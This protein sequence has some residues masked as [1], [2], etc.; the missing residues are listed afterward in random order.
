[1]ARPITAL[2]VRPELHVP[3]GSWTKDMVHTPEPL[4]PFGADVYL[5]ILNHA[6]GCVAEEF[7]VLIKGIEYLSLGG[8]VYSLTIPLVA[9]EGRTPAGWT[10]ATACRIV[11]VLRSRCHAAAQA[12]SSGKLDLL[13][14]QWESEWKPM[15][16][17]QIAE[18]LAVDLSE[19]SDTDLL[20]ELDQLVDL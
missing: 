8:E 16:E 14:K 9:T 4:T 17:T 20:A 18:H 3:P 6:I 5:P 19:L 11:P 13:P 7:G 15:F 1:Q 12:V 2:P 10:L